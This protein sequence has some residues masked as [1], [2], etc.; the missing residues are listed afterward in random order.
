MIIFSNKCKNWKRI[1][2]RIRLLPFQKLE[3][4]ETAEVE[5][6]ELGG[7]SLSDP[8]W[9]DSIFGNEKL[10]DGRWRSSRVRSLPN[11]LESENFYSNCRSDL[12]IKE[13][14]RSRGASTFLAC[15]ILRLFLCVNLE[16]LCEILHCNEGKNNPV[17]W[18]WIGSARPTDVYGAKTM[19]RLD[20]LE[21]S[22]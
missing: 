20:L 15:Q 10:G 6:E 7:L 5:D 4:T 17:R 9:G 21:T 19:G 8:P 1:R 12:E 22:P 14:W 13:W 11:I 3:T 18:R 2:F 16:K